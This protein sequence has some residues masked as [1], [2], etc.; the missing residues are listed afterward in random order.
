[1]TTVTSDFEKRRRRALERKKRLGRRASYNKI[2]RRA[3]YSSTTV[4]FVLKDQR[5][6]ALPIDREA[7]L[8][9]VLDALDEL[10]PDELTE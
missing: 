5:D 2:A 8:D 7:V 3:G 1:M 9:R 6:N 10:T 4:Q